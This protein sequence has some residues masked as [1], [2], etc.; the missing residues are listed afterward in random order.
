MG[1]AM[2]IQEI[3][4]FKELV[5][6]YYHQNKRSFVWRETITP[7]YVLVS[8]IML[9]QTQT[10]RVAVKFPPFIERFPTIQSLAAAPWHDVLLLW[11]GLGYNRRALNLQKTAQKLVA[12]HDGE[13]PDL[14][15]LLEECPGIGPATARSII[16][17]S[18]NKPTVFIETNVRA[19]FIHH[20]FRDKEAVHD[21]ELFPL[22][23]AATDQD[24]PREWYYALMD[25]GVMLKKQFKNPSRKSVHH[26]KQSKFQGSDRQLRGKI[27]ELLL[28]IK[29]VPREEL[30]SLLIA[31]YERLNK[32][33]D[34][35]VAE[36]LI[37]E[38][39]GVL[40]L[41]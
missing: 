33:I 5:W 4:S 2:S 3:D 16:A 7:Y 34:Q 18:Y 32:I 27:L 19:V 9:Q 15:A 38:H 36:H 13:V 41:G 10:D 17:F 29:K 35:L 26:T 6:N 39:E 8:E 20:F 11:K 23:E 24:N 14:P 40:F 1:P 21:K 22:I 30:P 37:F 28:S 12:Q 25:Y 31:D